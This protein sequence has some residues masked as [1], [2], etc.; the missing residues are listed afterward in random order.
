MAI[1]TIDE[2]F[3]EYRLYLKG[4]KPTANVDQNDSDWWIKGRTNSGIV[5]GAYVE[6]E[7]NAQDAFPQN[8]RREALLR[9][10]FAYFN[11]NTFLPATVA[12]GNVNLTGDPLAPFSAGL[13]LTHEASG[14]VYTVTDSGALGASGTGSAHVQSLLAG[15]SQNLFAATQLSIESAP[16]GIDG[17]AFVDVDGIR[18]GTN[19]E[20]ETRASV[21]VLNRMQ[22]SE[23]GGTQADYK[24]WAL[25]TAGVTSV[26]I[27]RYLEGLG[28]VGVVITSGTTD[29]DAALDAVPEQ[30]ITFTPS[31][32]LI[33]ELQA[34]LEPASDGDAAE[35]DCPIVVGAVEVEVD[36]T[37]RVAFVSGDKDTVLSGQT[38]TQGELVAKEVKRAIYK[39]PL[40]GAKIE[41][42]YFVTEKS[43]DDMI[44]SKL[45]AD[46]DG[47]ATVV[48]ETLQIVTNRKISIA[49]PATP[50]SVDFAVGANQRPIPGTITILDWSE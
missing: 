29:I 3:E 1:K 50:Q 44:A 33:A 16:E 11:E 13:Q 31:G 19:E 30:A 6:S 43:I 9:H 48:G 7:K 15:Q 23:R 37:A 22:S 8:A 34:K 45:G 28:T 5:A 46:V 2:I 12:S 14:N 10:I 27:L 35:T 4:L 38:L 20:D 39:T 21:R 32:A 49:S 41:S 25:E 26:S 36:V 40:G 42:T 18:D 24:A 17:M 47:T